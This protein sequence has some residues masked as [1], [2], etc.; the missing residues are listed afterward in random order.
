MSYEFG[1]TILGQAVA[2]KVQHDAMNYKPKRRLLKM[3]KMLKRL[4]K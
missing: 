4:T 2:A 1:T 3:K